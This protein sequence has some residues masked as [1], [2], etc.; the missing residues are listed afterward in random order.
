IFSETRNLLLWPDKL[1]L[2]V[3]STKTLAYSETATIWN[4]F[5]YHLYDATRA[6]FIL[7][8]QHYKYLRFNSGRTCST[9]LKFGKPF[10]RG[11]Y[12]ARKCGENQ[13]GR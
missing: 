6:R 5:H 8:C 13:T 10:H 3:S 1:S 12:D 2:H 11:K 9:L 7:S 4:D